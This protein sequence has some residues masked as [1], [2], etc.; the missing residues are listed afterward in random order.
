MCSHKGGSFHCFVLWHIFDHSSRLA[1]SSNLECLIPSAKAPCGLTSAG[2]QLSVP[3][4]VRGLCLFPTVNE[5]SVAVIGFFLHLFWDLSAAMFWRNWWL[6]ASFQKKSRLRIYCRCKNCPLNF[7]S[8]FLST[9]NSEMKL[10]MI[11]IFGLFV[12]FL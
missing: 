1:A 9:N 5:I 11:D 3:Q 12:R 8:N 4:L 7:P 6:I 2:S 10:S